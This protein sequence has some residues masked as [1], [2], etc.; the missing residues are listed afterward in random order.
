MPLGSRIK[1]IAFCPA[2][3]SFILL[4]FG[5]GAGSGHAQ[6]RLNLTPKRVLILHTVAFTLP[7]HEG[8]SP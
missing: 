1:R 5:P 2:L 4:V 3:F 8:D 6:A 7:A